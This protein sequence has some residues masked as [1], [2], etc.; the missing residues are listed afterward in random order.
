M[1]IAEV[2]AFDDNDS[3]CQ[4]LKGE[5]RLY[6]IAW[7]ALTD[8]VVRQLGQRGIA[9]GSFVRAAISQKKAKGGATEIAK[10]GAKEGAKKKKKKKKQKKQK[11]REG[12]EGSEGPGR[13][14]GRTAGGGGGEGRE[15]TA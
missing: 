10:E 9:A 11:Q 7:E 8:G 15:E 13:V 14:A 6:G 1:R 5:V 3:A 2:V 12:P 4:P